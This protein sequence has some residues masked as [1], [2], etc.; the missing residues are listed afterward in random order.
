MAVRDKRPSSSPATW[1]VDPEEAGNNL[2]CCSEDS[3]FMVYVFSFFSMTSRS[4]QQ[5]VW[6]L[7]ENS[8]P[9]LQCVHA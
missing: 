1:F 9:R 5:R 2:M 7:N 8:T 4:E 3:I 6:G